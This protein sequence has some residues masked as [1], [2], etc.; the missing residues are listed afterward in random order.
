[1]SPMKFSI[2]ICSEPSK[3]MIMELDNFIYIE[4]VAPPDLCKHPGLPEV[5]DILEESVDYL[6]G[7]LIKPDIFTCTQDRKIIDLSGDQIILAENRL[8]SSLNDINLK[9]TGKKTFHVPRITTDQE[10]I[11]ILCATLG[12][13]Y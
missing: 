8:I 9:F 1:M 10:C 4:P 7:L 3:R 11:V 5:I 13:N 12:V 6:H 2:T